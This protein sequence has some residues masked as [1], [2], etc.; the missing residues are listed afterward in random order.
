MTANGVS[1]DRTEQCGTYHC[2]NCHTGYEG[3]HKCPE[4]SD[5]VKYTCDDCGKHVNR[6]THQ[7]EIV[8]VPPSR[9]VS[10][11]FDRM[12]EP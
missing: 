7:M 9:C 6:E 5:R 10:C 8:G 2:P 11:T 3:Y 4:G 12:A 1:Q